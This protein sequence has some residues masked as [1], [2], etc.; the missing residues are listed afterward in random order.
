MERNQTRSETS[1]SIEITKLKMKEKI[2]RGI[3]V[4]R[5]I[6]KVNLNFKIKMERK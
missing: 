2:V 3:R 4:R 5:E 1:G 6:G